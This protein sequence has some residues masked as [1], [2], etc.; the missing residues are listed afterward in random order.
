VSEIGLWKLVSHD[1]SRGIRE[2]SISLPRE[3]CRKWDELEF[4][5]GMWSNL[6]GVAS[7]SIWILINN[8]AYERAAS[9]ASDERVRDEQR[10]KAPQNR[11]VEGY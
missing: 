3:S 6:A 2:I 10:R 5:I 8:I 4:T 1:V 11:S 7:A 9:R